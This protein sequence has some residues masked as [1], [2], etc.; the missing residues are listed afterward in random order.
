MSIQV[1]DI[2]GNKEIIKGRAD[3]ALG[4]GTNKLCTTPQKENNR[5]GA[6]LHVDFTYYLLKLQCHSVV[7]DQSEE[8]SRVHIVVHHLNTGGCGGS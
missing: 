3:W 1:K 5:G 8:R 7:T 2:Y 4:H 6:R